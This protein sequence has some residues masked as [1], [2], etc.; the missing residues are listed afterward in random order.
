LTPSH[1]CMVIKRLQV[2][3]AWIWPVLASR[4]L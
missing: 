1:M 3:N 4:E 2:Q